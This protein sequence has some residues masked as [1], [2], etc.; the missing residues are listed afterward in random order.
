MAM[1]QLLLQEVDQTK[2]LLSEQLR[3][4][5]SQFVVFFI[6]PFYR[7]NFYGTNVH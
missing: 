4:R 1:L 7:I 5:V 3:K 2:L 6:F